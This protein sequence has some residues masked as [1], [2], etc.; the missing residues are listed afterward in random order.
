M[1][2]LRTL[3]AFLFLLG[4]SVPAFA[5]EVGPAKPDSNTSSASSTQSVTSSSDCSVVEY[6]LGQCDAEK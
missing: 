2:M 4:L 5:D 6:L 1:K 3:I